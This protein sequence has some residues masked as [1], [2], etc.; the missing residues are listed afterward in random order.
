[1]VIGVDDLG[2]HSL[3]D[4]AV[5]L[6]ARAIRGLSPLL[7]KPGLSE[8]EELHLIRSSHPALIPTV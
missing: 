5:P 4:N 6:S 1:M 7:V 8:I 3:S 2:L